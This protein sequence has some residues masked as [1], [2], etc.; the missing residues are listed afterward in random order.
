M[1]SGDAGFSDTAS[2]C[3]LTAM[4]R[5]SIGRCEL[6]A[7]SVSGLSAISTST[8]TH[9]SSL[10]DV[11]TCHLNAGKRPNHYCIFLNSVDRLCLLCLLTRQT[12]AGVRLDMIC[13]LLYGYT[14]VSG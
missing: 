13:V 1:G 12:S 4:E 5:G 2:V 14:F 6:K 10:H 7:Y 9:R 11:N 8:C 3:A